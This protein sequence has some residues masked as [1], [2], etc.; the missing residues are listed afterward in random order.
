[1]EATSSNANEGNP[2]NAQTL[3]Q[4]VA[5][6]LAGKEIK[7]TGSSTAVSCVGRNVDKWQH[8]LTIEF[9]DKETTGAG[10]RNDDVQQVSRENIYSCTILW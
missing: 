3:A 6:L 10:R 5:P 9:V 8:D 2:L 4:L 1:M 7:I